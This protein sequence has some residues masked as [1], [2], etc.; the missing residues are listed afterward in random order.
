MQAVAL[1]LLATFLIGFAKAGIPGLGILI[2]P[3]AT[4]GAGDAS[5]AIGYLLPL[6][7]VGDLFC[8]WRYFGKWDRRIVVTMAAGAVIGVLLASPLL[9]LL[10][11]QKMLFNRVM[12]GLAL[13]FGGWQLALEL[14]RRPAGEETP[15]RAPWHHAPW[16]GVVAG[17]LTAITSTI[18][19]QGG[20]VSNLYLVSLKM[21]KE[22]FIATAT[23]AYF[24]LNCLK[25]PAYLENGLINPDSLRHNA[26]TFPLVILGGF[27]GAWVVKR[28]SPGAFTRV[29]LVLVLAAGV[30]LL[31]WP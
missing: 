20:L 5:Y 7:I 30:K 13:F 14:R 31:V 1:V 8:G 19:H 6:L 28:V 2:G 16:L 15:E 11:E 25:V 23:G 9:G 17:T 3:I 22:R 26:Q 24:I 21:T 18:A 4:L 29:I 10:A 12:G 27:A